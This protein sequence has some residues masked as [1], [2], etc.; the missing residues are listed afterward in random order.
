MKNDDIILKKEVNSGLAYVILL[1]IGFIIVFSMVSYIKEK[2][3][4]ITD[5]YTISE[6]Y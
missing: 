2:A 4:D 5:G 1:A 3:E 6:N